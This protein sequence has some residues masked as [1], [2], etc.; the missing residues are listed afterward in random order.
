MQ[1]LCIKH[2]PLKLPAKGLSLHATTTSALPKSTTRQLRV[3]RRARGPDTQPRGR[4]EALIRR[5]V[6]TPPHGL[7]HPLGLA[8]RVY[9]AHHLQ[10]Q[11][12]TVRRAPLQ[13]RAR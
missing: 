13:C 3:P 10:V 7:G 6:N 1:E 4:V 9:H 12:R 8:A 2:T 11:A 5:A